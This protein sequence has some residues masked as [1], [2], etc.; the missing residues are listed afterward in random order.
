MSS[1]SVDI[2]IGCEDC[3]NPEVDNRPCSM[4]CLETIDGVS[5]Y[6]CYRCNRKVTI[7]IQINGVPLGA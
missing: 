5:M 3:Y 4:T 2:D 6:I 7:D 1:L